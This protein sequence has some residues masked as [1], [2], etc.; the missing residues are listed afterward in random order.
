MRYILGGV[1]LELILKIVVI[2]TILSFGYMIIGLLKRENRDRQKTLLLTAFFILCPMIGIACFLISAIS[3]KLNPAKNLDVTGIYFSDEKFIYQKKENYQEEIDITP[4][5]DVLRMSSIKDKRER[6]LQ[7]IKSDINA[8]MATYSAA[9]LSEDSEVSH[10]AA[11]MLSKARD[12]YERSLNRLSQEYDG[13]RTD[14]RV[15]LAYIDA[16][17][18]YLTSGIK[19][20]DEESK[21]Y[22]YSFVWLCENL[23]KHH[24]KSLTEELFDKTINYYIELSE[25]GKARE[26]VEL[27]T[28]TYPKS[29][30][31]YKAKLHFSFT[32]GD[33]SGFFQSMSELRSS[34]IPVSA[35]T[36]DLIR[37]FITKPTAKQGGVGRVN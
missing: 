8:G 9:V 27:F 10:Y 18:G 21:K 5:D 35:E 32:I 30:I 4:L 26:W 15:N 14:E 33:S 13:D 1:N 36:I 23:N 22:M 2:N 29:E 24:P 7:S 11:A 17:H 3:H 20:V 31:A 37:F 12:S 6:L 34:G 19:L 28:F 16:V 25:L